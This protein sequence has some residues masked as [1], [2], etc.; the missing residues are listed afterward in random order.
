VLIVQKARLRFMRWLP[1]KREVFSGSVSSA[2]S[3]NEFGRSTYLP[4]VPGSPSAGRQHQAVNLLRRRIKKRKRERDG[5][6]PAVCGAGWKCGAR[7]ASC[8][9]ARTRHVLVYLAA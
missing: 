1:D 3:P 4:R 7:R 9:E 2:R 8:G 5:F 6:R